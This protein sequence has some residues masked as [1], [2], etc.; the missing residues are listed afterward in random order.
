MF[1]L[2]LPAAFFFIK[3]HLDNI[4]F[5]HN[6]SQSTLW[7]ALP[8]TGCYTNYYDRTKQIVSIV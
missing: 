5:T 2:L 7:E 4:T 1:K 8:N 6:S 3:R